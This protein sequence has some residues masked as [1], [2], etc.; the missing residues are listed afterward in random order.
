MPL[1]LA[2]KVAPFVLYSII[3]SNSAFSLP[4]L[5][6]HPA[7]PVLQC[8]W[9]QSNFA[10][11]LFSFQAP[12]LSYLILLFYSQHILKT[13]HRVLFLSFPTTMLD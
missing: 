8:G 11:R 6:R 12:V 2:L 3:L 10:A 4:V 13:V 5:W 9:I 1:H 7:F